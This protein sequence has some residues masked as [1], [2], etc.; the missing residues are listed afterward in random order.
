MASFHY[1]EFIFFIEILFFFLDHI[2]RSLTTFYVLSIIQLEVKPLRRMI[3]LFDLIEV[4]N[5]NDYTYVL[6]TETKVFTTE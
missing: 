3:N 4:M 5:I 1:K 2:Y 6:L